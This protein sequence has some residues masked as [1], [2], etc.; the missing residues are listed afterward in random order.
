MLGRNK[1]RA[2]PRVRSSQGL[3]VTTAGSISSP[4]GGKATSQVP[5]P[6]RASSQEQQE[7]E[8]NPQCRSERSIQETGY[9]QHRSQ[10]H[11]VDKPRNTHTYNI[12]QKEATGSGTEL[13]WSSSAYRQRERVETPGEAAQGH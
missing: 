1:S 2:A 4:E 11:P 13:K 5:G 7:I 8:T 12:A 6:S 10:S 9:L 3:R